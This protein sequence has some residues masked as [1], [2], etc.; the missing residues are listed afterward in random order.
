[1]LLFF[2][3]DILATLLF[4]YYW[5]VNLFVCSLNSLF[6]T[7]LVVKNIIFDDFHCLISVLICQFRI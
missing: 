6:T 4:D 2:R 1:M 7:I 3:M 5:C